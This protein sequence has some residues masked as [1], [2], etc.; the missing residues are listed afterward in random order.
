MG[1]NDPNLSNGVDSAQTE[2]ASERPADL[3]EMS[4]RIKWFD[5]S[6]GYGFIVPD[7]GGA[8]VLLHVTAL[9][10]DGFQTAP[11]GAREIGRAHV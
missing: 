3:V 7:N 4:G 10:R 2:N 8:D 11:E 6:K 9:R 1:S 5:V